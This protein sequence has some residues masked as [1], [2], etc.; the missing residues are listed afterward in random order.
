MSD[1]LDL[2]Q[3]CSC[4]LTYEAQISFKSCVFIK[5]FQEQ[6]KDK[7]NKYVVL[8]RVNLSTLTNTGKLFARQRKLLM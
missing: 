2:S 6:V 3:F 8:T 7:K 5:L 1:I 4:K